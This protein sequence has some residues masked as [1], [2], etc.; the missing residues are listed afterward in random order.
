MLFVGRKKIILRVSQ[1]S[2]DCSGNQ[3]R[4]KEKPQ[5]QCSLSS[6]KFSSMPH[7]LLKRYLNNNL[8]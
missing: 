1:F 2:R 3:S 5:A 8:K 7:Y 6:G 4:R